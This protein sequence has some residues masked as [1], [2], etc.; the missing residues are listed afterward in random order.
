MKG[1][2]TIYLSN[3]RFRLLDL[4]SCFLSDLVLYSNNSVLS[5]ML[6]QRMVLAWRIE[7]RRIYSVL[8]FVDNKCT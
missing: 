3:S 8:S 6:S 1:H 4:F 5:F 2:E 7:F